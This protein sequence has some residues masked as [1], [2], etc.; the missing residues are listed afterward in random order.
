MTFLAA[1]SAQSAPAAASEAQRAL[2]DANAALLAR[3]PQ[4]DAARSALD[5]AIA[6]GDDPGATSEAYFRRGALD[7][8]DLEFA[9]ALT[10]YR[11]CAAATAAH[12]GGRWARN[13]DLRIRWLSARS[14]GDFVPL[15]RLNGVKRDPAASSDPAAME[16]FARDV[17]TFPP[18]TVRG[19]S[20]VLIGT[21]WLDLHRPKD[22]IREF[23]KVVT[24]P[25]AEGI[26]ARFAKRGLVDALL[27][28]GQLEEASQ[29][30]EMYALQLEPQVVVRIRRLVRRRAL[31][32]GSEIGLGAS[33]LLGTMV[34]VY[35]RWR[36]GPGALRRA[37]SS[38]RA[39]ARV[40]IALLC[41]A[42][43]VA[44]AFVLA[45]TSAPAFLERLSL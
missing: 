16:A 6:A 2:G 20:R 7:E 19:A 35:L 30:V 9:R 45:G 4:H 33:A 43:V 40:A 21:A 37:W 26:D 13:A 44:S 32:R 38:T 5:R 31:M 23:R 41:A 36:R 14:E 15:A 12:A 29:Q 28:D 25:R 11:A 18:G 22:A 24:D 10:D 1:L 39:P 8:E 3:P 42:A 27:T 17:D 34:L